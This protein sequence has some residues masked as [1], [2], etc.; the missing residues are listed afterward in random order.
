MDDDPVNVSKQLF[1]KNSI[2]ILPT[3]TSLLLKTQYNAVSL[4]AGTR[5]GK[6]L[7]SCVS[8]RGELQQNEVQWN[9]KDI[10]VLD[11]VVARR[12]ISNIH[13]ATLS[14]S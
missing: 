3:L 13:L 8:S 11:V 2:K 7:W 10:L 4:I 1:C 5:R 6:A 12:Y 14:H 9:A